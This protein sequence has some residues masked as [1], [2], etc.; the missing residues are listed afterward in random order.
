ME[1]AYAQKL[2]H[3]II[4]IV[5][6]HCER[7]EVAGSIRRKK[8]EVRDIDIVLIPKPLVWH[9]IISTLQRN[10]AAKVVKRGDSIA[11]LIIQNVSVDLYV[12]TPETWGTMLLIRT[13][14][15]Q[16]NIKL[17]GIA[18]RKGMKLT[19]SGLTKDGKV[20]ATSE[21]EIFESLGLSYI[22]PEER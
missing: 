15:A 12:A 1:L 14:S 3:E 18:L 19:H 2:A 5:R 8:S 21:K 11:Q 6:P 7:I 9:R 10:M 16:H 13:G 4:E 22:E 20:I 17:S